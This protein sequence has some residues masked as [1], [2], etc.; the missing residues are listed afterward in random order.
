MFQR[1]WGGTENGCLFEKQGAREAY[2]GT[3]A[4][5]EACEQEIKSRKPVTQNE[6][7]G[8]FFCGIQ[9]GKDFANVTRVD[10]ETEKCP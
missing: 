9:G 8:K 5:S 3:E 2:V 10:P 4:E 7:Y 1:E 6:F